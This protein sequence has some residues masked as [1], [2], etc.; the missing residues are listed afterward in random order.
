MSHFTFNM[1]EITSCG[2]L[3]QGKKLYSSLGFE[4][5]QNLLVNDIQGAA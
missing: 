2:K 5:I 1:L 3:S 4:R